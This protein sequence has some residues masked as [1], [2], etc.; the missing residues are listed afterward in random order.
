MLRGAVAAAL[1]GLTATTVGIPS[2]SSFLQTARNYARLVRKKKQEIPSHLDDLPPTMLMKSY[3]N[4]PIIDKVDDVVKRMLSLEMASQRERTEIKKEQLAE[5]V[6]K[7]P[8]DNCSLEVKVAYLTVKIRT[9]QE[10][11]QKHPKDKKNKTRMM[12]AIDQQNMLLKYLRNREYDVFENTC[13]QLDIQYTLPPQYRRRAT[14]RW[15][16][17]KAFCIKV[18]KEVKKQKALMKLKQR[19]ESTKAA[20]DQKDQAPPNAGTPV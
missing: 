9:L 18:F 13:K 1:R 4:V 6:R 16:V 7:S 5:K 15:V 12:M 11:L 19:Q 20:K 8:D 2:K 10:H 14:R 17:K 3:A